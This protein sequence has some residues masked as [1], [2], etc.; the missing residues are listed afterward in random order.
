MDINAFVSFLYTNKEKSNKLIKPKE[1]DKQI[2]MLYNLLNSDDANNTNIANLEHAGYFENVLWPSF[3]ESSKNEVI[4]SILKII[5]YKISQKVNIWDFFSKEEKIF[6]NLF[7]KVTNLNIQELSPSD[8]FIYVSFLI[9][10]FQSLEIG[11]ISKL[12]SKLINLPIWLRLSKETMK[13]SLLL[14]SKYIKNW[15]K[16]S[17]FASEIYI[18]K[19]CF[20]IHNLLDNFLQI[21]EKD[22]LENNSNFLFYEKFMEFLIDLLSQLHYRKFLLPLLKDRHFSELCIISK[23]NKK[24]QH[25]GNFH[26][27]YY[28]I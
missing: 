13:E 2:S 18:T 7:D 11:Y 24:N 28:T 22:Q 26:R 6:I 16:V 15:K 12:C 21:L 14:H 8:R 1:F 20:F 19:E 27:K 17:Q 4:L 3:S 10:C 25:E 23:L 9:N 5:N